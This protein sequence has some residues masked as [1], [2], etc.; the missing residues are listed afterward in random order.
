[1]MKTS[2]PAGMPAVCLHSTSALMFIQFQHNGREFTRLINRVAHCP[3]MNL[4]LA[5]RD[6]PRPRSGIGYSNI[7]RL[8][9][10]V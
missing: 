4:K 1:M 5:L 3:R 7:N 9:V 8:S 6:Y 10:V 2:M